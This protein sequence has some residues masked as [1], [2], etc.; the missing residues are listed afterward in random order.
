MNL[1]EIDLTNKTWILLKPND[2]I[3]NNICYIISKCQELDRLMEIGFEL[4]AILPTNKNHHT[5]T[6]FTQSQASNFTNLISF[7]YEIRKKYRWSGRVVYNMLKD[8]TYHGTLIQ[9]K[10]KRISYK[11]HKCIQSPKEHWIISNNALEKIF[12]DETWNAIQYKFSKLE[13][14]EL[15]GKKHIFSGKVFCDVCD[16]I[17]HKNSS[18]KIKTVKKLNTLYAKT[19]KI[20][21]ITAPIIIPLN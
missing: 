14:S 18:K 11:N 3:P 12:D 2:I 16:N 10:T 20:T 1:Q 21:G 13:R 4:E 17:L 8:E 9:G 15:S 6:L 5:Y 19:N 7:I